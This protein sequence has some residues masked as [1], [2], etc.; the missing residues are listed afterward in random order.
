MARPDPLILSMEPVYVVVV[1]V[2]FGSARVG[3]VTQVVEAL[4]FAYVIRLF[5]EFVRLIQRAVG[6]VALK[7]RNIHRD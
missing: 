2:E 5:W 6:G 7:T 3:A 1:Y 4:L